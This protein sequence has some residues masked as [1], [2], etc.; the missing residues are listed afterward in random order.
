MLRVCGLVPSLHVVRAHVNASVISQRTLG[1]RGARVASGARGAGPSSLIALGASGARVGSRP[2]K[3]VH[4]AP[5]Q[6]GPPNQEETHLLRKFYLAN[7]GKSLIIG[8]RGGFF[9]PENS[10]KCFN[11]AIE[12]KLEGVE[13]DVW[14]S[15][16]GVPMVLHGGID[17]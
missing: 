7:P 10:L 11:L 9:G 13:F 12:N 16:D 14:L 5:A 15:K 4:Q 17:G 1:A 6:A 3:D 8:H 2:P